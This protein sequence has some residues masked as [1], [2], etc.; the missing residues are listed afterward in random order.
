MIPVL[1]EIGP[2][3]IYSYGLMLGI[4]FIL[5]S[6]ILSL[7]LERKKL[8]PNLAS[9]ITLLAVVFG[10]AGAKLLYLIEHWSLFLKDPLDMA[11]SA[12][13]LTWYGGFIVGMTAVFLYVKSKKVPFLKI[14]D[15]LGLA[16]ILAYG[17]GRVGCHLSGDG[18]YGSPT[19]LPW[20]TIYAE[21]VAKPT[22][23]LRDYFERFPEER[24]VWAYDS[25]QV[26]RTGNDRLGKP[27]TR[28]DE[29]TTCHPTPIYELILGVVGFIFL[30]NL[31]KKDF[32]DGKLFMI[33]L[34]VASTFR[35]FVEHLR[36]QPRLFVGLSEA[37]LVSIGLFVLGLAGMIFLNK[38]HTT[39]VARMA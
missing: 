17:V 2:V 15:G 34:M 21:G 11:F 37:Q 25:L 26:I 6:Y 14:W 18:D 30:W 10:I 35:F 31:R 39:K 22:V 28:F 3:K 23:M 1:F 12:G 24:S 27:I 7:E 9:T 8:Q 20:G 29:V 19:R 33:Y 5:G 13:G 36:L 38:R 16:L 4:A 32:P